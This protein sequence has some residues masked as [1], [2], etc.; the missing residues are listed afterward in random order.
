M[1]VD[2]LMEDF[3]FQ[4]QFCVFANPHTFYSVITN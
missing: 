2:Q 3:H 1:N 4:D